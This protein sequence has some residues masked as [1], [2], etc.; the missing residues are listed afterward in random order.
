M[1]VD[2]IRGWRWILQ[3]VNALQDLVEIDTEELGGGFFKTVSAIRWNIFMCQ[4]YKY[5]YRRAGRRFFYQLFVRSHDIHVSP[6]ICKY[7]YLHMCHF[8]SDHRT[9]AENRKDRVLGPPK[10]VFSSNERK[11]CKSA[12][13]PWH[14]NIRLSFG[15]CCLFY[16]FF[17]SF[18]L[19]VF[20]LF[21][22]F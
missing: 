6:S 12:K 4:K 15:S 16:S 5:N 11:H 19:F 18:C 7:S 8:Y 2:P 17:L 9:A 22:F 13:L 14:H 21:V 10:R 20:C 3:R 1:E